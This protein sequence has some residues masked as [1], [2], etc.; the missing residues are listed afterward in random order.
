MKG[1]YGKIQRSNGRG[2]GAQAQSRRARVHRGRRLFALYTR[3]TGVCE[4][5]QDGTLQKLSSA[6]VSAKGQAA[7]LKNIEAKFTDTEREIFLRG[8]N[9]KKPT[10]SKNATVAEYN[11]STGFEAVVGYLY[12]T[13][14]YA[15]LDDLLSEEQDEVRG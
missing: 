5:L 8:R 13:G 7:L 9:A 15:R 1:Y 2:K 11:L 10:K 6:S 3:K 12:L 4:R 14:A